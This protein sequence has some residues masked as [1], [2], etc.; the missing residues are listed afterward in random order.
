[1]NVGTGRLRP[2]SAGDCTADARGLA[3]NCML[4]ALD[5]LDRD[6]GISPAIGAQLQLAIDRLVSSMP[7]GTIVR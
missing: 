2:T 4:A 6:A 1:M 5:H 7:A 3:L